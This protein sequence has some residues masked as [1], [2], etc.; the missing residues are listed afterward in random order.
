[1]TNPALTMTIL[2]MGAF[3]AGCFSAWNIPISVVLYAP[4]V[5]YPFLV[6]INHLSPVH[7][8]YCTVLTYIMGVID[9]YFSW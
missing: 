4:F 8:F 7:I 6:P 1:M 2:T 9:V 3:V 5:V